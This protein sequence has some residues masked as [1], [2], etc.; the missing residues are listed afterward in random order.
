MS[1][2]SKAITDLRTCPTEACSIG[3]NEKL[4]FARLF[5]V[6]NFRFF[7]QYR[8]L[9]DFG[10]L[11]ANVRFRGVNSTDQRNIF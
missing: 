1:V 6:L 8:P 5:E 4:T 7:Q 3:D 10:E 9:A 2:L 11:S